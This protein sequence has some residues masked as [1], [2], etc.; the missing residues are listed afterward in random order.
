MVEGGFF[1]TYKRT[2]KKVVLMSRTVRLVHRE[3]EASMIA[4]QLLLCQ[5]AWRCLHRARR[6]SR[7]V[8]PAGVLLEARREISAQGIPGAVRGKDRPRRRDRGCRTREQKR[9]WPRRKPQR[10]LIRRFC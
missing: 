6:A 7:D 4:T 8:Q 1:R 9:E 10:P 2:L 3:A 5:G